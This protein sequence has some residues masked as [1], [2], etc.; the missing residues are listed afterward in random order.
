MP[1]AFSALRHRE[2]RLFLG[3]QVISLCGTWMQNLAQIW[4][5]YRITHS[6]LLMGTLGFASLF[7]VLVFGPVAGLVADRLPRRT[8]VLWAQWAFLFQSLALAVLTLTDR[9]TVPLLMVLAIVAGMI[10]AF[11]I[12]A[13]QSLF[14]HLVGEEDLQNAIALNSMTFNMARV[15]GPSLAGF[16][17][18]SVGEGLCFLFNS[19]S[20]LAV[21]VSLWMIRTAEPVRDSAPSPLHHLREGFGYAWNTRP[22]RIMLFVTA[23]ANLASAPVATLVPVFS[24]GIFGRGSQGVGMLTGC[25]GAGA[26]F[27]TY[28]LAGQ[29]HHANLFRVVYFS[30]LTTVAGLVVY[31]SSP[32]F[33]LTL[34]ASATLGFGIFRQLASTNSLIQSTIPDDY[35]GRIMSLY[36]MTVVGMLPLGNLAAGA[37]AHLIGVRWTVAAGALLSAAAALLWRREFPSRIH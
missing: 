8:I 25:L 15:V 35:R 19:I 24:D 10:N 17:V 32:A 27:G 31:A 16:L 2:F 12:P 29:A 30:A 1:P 4:L 28:V 18:A 20:Y 11:D 22:V 26:V 36:S 34:L 33:P 23:L 13:R 9:I 3:G 5:V 6:T 21:I 37:A 7:P 14:I